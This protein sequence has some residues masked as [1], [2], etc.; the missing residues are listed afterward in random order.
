MNTSL[1]LTAASLVLTPV[2]A[3]QVTLVGHYKLDETS[4]TF[5]A[6]SSGLGHHGT[7]MNGAAL[8]VPGVSGASGRAVD[9][10]GTTGY[11]EIPG[12]AIFDGLRDDLSIAAWIQTDN[13]QLQRI[14]SN[15]R[16]TFTQANSGSWSFG[17]T[18]T[19]LRFTTLMVQDYNQA[20]TLTAQQWHHLVVTFDVNF[21]AT[22]YV[23]GVSVGQ[24]AGFAPSNAPSQNNRYLIGVLDP[25]GGTTPEWFD[26]RI[27]DVQFYDGTLTAAEVAFL[28]ANPGVAI[29][30]GLGVTY[31]SPA[32]TNSGGTAAQM[33]ASGSAV[34]A[35]NNLTLECASM[36]NNSFGFFLTSRTQGS[37]LQPGGSQGRLCLSGAIGRYV[38]P[39][40]IKNSGANGAIALAVNLNQH[41]SPS[42]SL[43]VQAGDTWHFTAWFRDV[44]GG[45]ATSNFANGLSITFQ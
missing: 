34:V 12:N 25:S 36:P 30:G 15:D 31:C 39:G 37:I 42:G 35:Q 38:G 17:T 21:V 2:A 8:G 40:Q 23:D 26:G 33:G 6:D 29:G 3:A 44:V 20:V 41:P 7:Y 43:I 45:Q 19:G 32:V 24:V 4:G 13:V 16:P 27:D 10:D 1:L 14:F 28:H 22:F 18:A 9:L 11:V 5:C